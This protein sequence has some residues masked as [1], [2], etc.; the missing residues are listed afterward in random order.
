MQGRRCTCFED[1]LVVF[2]L[3]CLTERSSSMLPANPHKAQVIC[4]LDGAQVP[5]LVQVA[6]D[7]ALD[8]DESWPQ[9]RR[10][11]QYSLAL[12]CSIFHAW[13]HKSKIL[14]AD[15]LTVSA[16]EATSG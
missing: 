1:H 11:V 6:L 3:L 12:L 9:P 7:S 8:V 5:R 15:R 10:T 14:L 2:V 16:S 4:F 13:R